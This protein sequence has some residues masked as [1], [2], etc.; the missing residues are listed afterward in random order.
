MPSFSGRAVHYDARSSTID[1]DK[2]TASL[3][4]NGGR[5]KVKFNVPLYFQKFSDW[6]VKES[7]LVKCKDGKFRLMI[8]VE[9]PSIKS[10]GTGRMIGVDRGINNLVATS[11]GWFF[12]GHDVFYRKQRYV[13]LRARLQ[14]KGTHSAKRHLGKM[15]GREKRFMADVNHCISRNLINAA[16]INGVLVLEN[17]KGIRKARHRREQNWL[18]S[19]W[20]FYQLE[21]FLK[22]K[23]GESGVAI[24]FVPARDTSK[25]CSVCGSL[26]KGQ[27][28][29]SVFKCKSCHVVLNADLNAAKNI[30]HRYQT[31]TG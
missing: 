14:A 23:G 3:L 8:S 9:K 25:A 20:A 29:G 18:F 24:E 4:T 22:Y 17:L 1:L 27:R 28:Q 7:N 6:K 13:R 12:E 26:R 5:L 16:G 2:K 10:N 15:R 21:G 11:S 19:N 30:L 31:L